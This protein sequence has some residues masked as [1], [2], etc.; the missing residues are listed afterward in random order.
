MQNNDNDD[1]DNTTDTPPE[2][3]S[4]S[5]PR[6]R[7]K[8]VAATVERPR[9]S[10]HIS[11]EAVVAK[12]DVERILKDLVADGVVK[13]IENEDGVTRYCADPGWVREE[14]LEA[15]R[16]CN[17]QQDLKDMRDEIRDRLTDVKDG[18][19]HRLLEFRLGLIEDEIDDT[20]FDNS[21]DENN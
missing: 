14:T 19:Q 4:Y 20:H 12:S 21:V 5:T 8:A 18:A 1:S 16:Q 13:S 7:V 3:T 2:W 6:D 9:A 17:S 10:T 11:T 15:L